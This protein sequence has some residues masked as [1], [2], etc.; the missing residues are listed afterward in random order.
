MKIKTSSENG[1][2]VWWSRWW[3]FHCSLLYPTEVGYKNPGADARFV[4]DNDDDKGQEWLSGYPPSDCDQGTKSLAQLETPFHSWQ[5]TP[6]VDFFGTLHHIKK[7]TKLRNRQSL[8]N[9]KPN[10]IFHVV[11]ARHDADDLML[12]RTSKGHTT[13]EKDVNDDTNTPPY[14]RE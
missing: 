7:R 1:F 2:P 3:L 13:R 8:Q 11:H 6:A 4:D 12:F 5:M 10:L 14:S 9:E